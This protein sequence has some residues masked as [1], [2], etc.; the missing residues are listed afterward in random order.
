MAEPATARP[1]IL[2][3][4]DEAINIDILVE[5]LS[6]DYDV[7]V[8]TSGKSA[9]AAAASSPP[10]LVLLDIMMPEMD[11]YEACRRLKADPA[12]AGIPVIFVTARVS[13]ADE[14][15]GFKLG[16]VDYI[17]KPISPPIVRA[18][19][20]VHLALLQARRRLEAQNETLVAHARLQ[21]D[22]ERMTR[23]DLKAPLSAVISVPGML[24][25]EG[26]LDPGQ[27]RLL[28]MLETAGFRMLAII[29]SSI[30]LFKMEQGRYTV[31]PE[32][33]DLAKIVRQIGSEIRGLLSA[34]KLAID[35]SIR[36]RPETPGMT[37]P[38]QGEE[39]LFYSLLVNLIQNAAEA[40]PE[41]ARILVALDD[42]QGVSIRIHNPG[43]VPTEIRD[44]FFEKY[45]TFGKTRGTGLGTYTA[46]LIT[47]TLGGTIGLESSAAHGTTVF[48]VLPR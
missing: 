2:V 36:D 20:G 13:E 9:L 10:D 5:I 44:R 23:H 7:S 33:V 40:S 15:L 43:A 8:A 12:T 35:V 28:D 39:I 29:N 48:A 45:A 1:D 41:G 47:E 16:A 19:V 22:V 26:N 3:V 32:P 21:E 18:R 42:R 46:R 25:T 37:F 4:D 30:N 6:D 14:A 24:K 31:V 11:G 34:K 27:V 17:T 38:A